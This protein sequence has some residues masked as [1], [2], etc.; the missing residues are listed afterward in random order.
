MKIKVPN[1]HADCFPFNTNT[2]CADGVCTDGRPSTQT[3]SAQM[4]AYLCRLSLRGY[5]AICANS[6]CVAGNFEIFQIS[7]VRF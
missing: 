1:I 4:A 5:P 6:V 7:M 2:I 3:Q